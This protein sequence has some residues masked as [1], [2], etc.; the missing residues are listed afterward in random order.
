MRWIYCKWWAFRWSH[1]K[2]FKW[3]EEVC[4]HTY[5]ACLLI[6]VVWSFVFF[7]EAKK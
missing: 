1:P 3:V 5:I 6:F 7:F 4:F 2:F